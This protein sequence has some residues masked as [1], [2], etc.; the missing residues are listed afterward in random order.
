MRV[1]GAKVLEDCAK[2]HADVRKQL[3]AWREDVQRATWT[4]PVQIKATYAAASILPGGSRV[5]F[6]IKGNDYRI[7]VQ[8]DYERGYVQIR[9]ADT[10]DEYDKIDA[11]TI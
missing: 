10:H 4:K 2:K 1:I 3:N 7:V 9:F 11:A 8:V 6:N 5:V